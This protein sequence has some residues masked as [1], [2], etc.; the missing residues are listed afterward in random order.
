MLIRI[1][2][3]SFI[4]SLFF[5]SFSSLFSFFSS[6]FFRF[7]VLFLSLSFSSLPILTPLLQLEKKSLVGTAQ[8]PKSSQ[9]IL[10]FMRMFSGICAFVRV[11][12]YGCM[13][14]CVRVVMAML[15]K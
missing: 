12:V 2:G 4:P 1:S 3:L 5:L 14:V 10:K 6:L 7:F 11:S 8:A 9:L 13:G 15:K